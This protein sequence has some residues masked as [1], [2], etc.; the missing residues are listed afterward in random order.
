MSQFSKLSYELT[1]D[2]NKDVKKKE[3]IFFTPL[4]IIKKSIK[5]INKLKL[6]INTILEPS[7]GS[8]EY[9]NYLKQEY[10]ESTIIG[11]EKN[12]KIYEKIK[13]DNIINAD[14]LEYETDVLFD[15]I[16]GNPPYFVCK[17]KMFK[18]FYTGRPN[19]YIL[20]II[21]CLNLL[22]KNGILSFVLPKNFLNCLYYDKLR[23]HINNNYKI[24]NIIDCYDEK[25]I[26][27]N[28]DT[29]IFIVQ[30]K[31][32][33]N[34]RFVISKIKEYTIFN[35]YKN[36]RAINNLLNDS[37]TLNELNFD[38]KVGNIVWNQ[39][40]NKLTDNSEYSRLIY[41]SDIKN[42]KLELAEFSCEDKK[43]YIDIDK[44]CYNG[45]M[46]LLNRGY[47]KGTYN[48]SYC[49]I[50]LDNYYVENHLIS[51]KSNNATENDYKN[52]INSLNDKRTKD[53]VKLYFNNSAINTTELKYILP[54]YLH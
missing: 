54:F 45:L 37:K 2:L 52:I 10:K 16:I 27:T 51:I 21:K 3:G 41:N 20:F 43:H 14:F 9:I 31:K 12:K 53:F 17:S 7:C 47:G 19:I 15:L 30:N 13:G 28:Q 25:Y 33:S 44:Q 29:I 24:I 42:N 22:S 23:K 36:V 6:K 4:N 5:E 49:L 32:G 46:L 1:K 38:V 8:C 40:K 48:F 18:E 34:K 11:I 26:E 35:T 50:N 39:V